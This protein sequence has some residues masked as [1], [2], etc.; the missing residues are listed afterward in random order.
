MSNENW[1]VEARC[2]GQDPEL[3]F[4]LGRGPAYEQQVTEAKKVCGGCPV[5]GE[6]LRFV[7]SVER[8]G[9]YRHGVFAGLTEDERR[10]L[11][12]HQEEAA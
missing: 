4:P 6:C 1:R 11:F 9:D 2:N 7:L 5:S 10:Q 12:D 3:F 8:P